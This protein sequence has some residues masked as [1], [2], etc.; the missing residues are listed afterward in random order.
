MK[1]FIVLHWSELSQGIG[2][3]IGLFNFYVLYYS[4][5]VS[6][7]ISFAIAFVLGFF[8]SKALGHYVGKEFNKHEA[9]KISEVVEEFEKQ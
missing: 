9:E 6:W 2:V 1:K 3:G 4:W 7:E 5:N 8:A